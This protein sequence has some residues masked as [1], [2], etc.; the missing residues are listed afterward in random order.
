MLEN[1]TNKPVKKTWQKP[2]IYLLDS[3]VETARTKHITRIHEGT[4]VRN[5]GNN[6]F[7]QAG[8]PGNFGGLSQ[9]SSYVS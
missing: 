4:G 8:N 2:E 9:L 6:T 7:H 5:P 3:N 1:A